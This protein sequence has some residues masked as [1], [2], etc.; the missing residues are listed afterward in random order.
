[1]RGTRSQAA[2]AAVKS[3]SSS[4]KPDNSLRR[5]VTDCHGRQTSTAPSTPSSTV[6]RSR[7]STLGLGTPATPDSCPSLRNADPDGQLDHLVNDLAADVQRC[8]LGT[9]ST[10]SVRPSQNKQHTTR[11]RSGVTTPSPPD[12]S[13]KS[14]YS[15]PLDKTPC[16]RTGQRA[17]SDLPLPLLPLPARK[18]STSLA[19]V[20]SPSARSGLST[21][22]RASLL[23]A[24]GIRTTSMP[25]GSLHRAEQEIADLKA[26]LRRA[27]DAA[28]DECA[29]TVAARGRAFAAEQEQRLCAARSA[30]EMVAVM[31]H[32]D[33]LAVRAE[34]ESLA[35]IRQMLAIEA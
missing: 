32:A 28:A 11:L 5:S 10:T 26:Q 20:G 35:V 2:A 1:M 29:L 12:T 31:A 22:A 18:I 4:N 15:T 16:P 23:N 6:S 30:W 25:N 27:K 7:Q 14:V 13:R 21:G 8:D 9:A 33:R 19:S 17:A 24:D 3:G 34:L